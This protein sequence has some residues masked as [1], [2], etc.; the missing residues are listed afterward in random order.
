MRGALRLGRI[1]GIEIGLDYS[2]FII[3][4]LVTWSLAGHYLTHYRWPASTSWMVGLLTSLIFFGSVLAHELGHSL[5]AIRRGVPV[6]GITLFIFGGIAQISKEPERPRD[7]LAIAIAGPI[8]SVLLGL[9]FWSL[10]V[11]APDPRQPAAALAS[12]LGRINVY[13]A[14]FNLLPGFPLDGGR[15]FR[16]IVWGYTGSYPRATRIAAGA[17]QVVAYGFIF[18]G[19][20]MFFAGNWVNGL[21]MAFIGWF[22]N[23]AAAGVLQQMLVREQLGGVKARDVMMTDCPVVSRQLTLQ[24]LVDEYLL[25]T[26]RRCFPVAEE[27]R[28]YGIITLPDVAA[29]PREQRPMVTVGEA[30][31]PFEAT[32]KV[33]PD[34]DLTRVLELMTAEDINQVLVV[35]NGKLLGMISRDRVL[36]FLATRAELGLV[37]GLGAL[38]PVSP[39][40]RPASGTRVRGM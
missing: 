24:D 36:S 6:Q 33:G 11:A 5:V 10:A 39:S 17:G 40:A 7:E 22:L 1:F 13:L 29:V 26:A 30:M 19:L 32:K 34:Q 25:K 23:N 3:F 2:W 16:A 8:V 15:V 28:V 12:W 4:A 31:T 20:S 38:R 14:A 21:W 35:E 9:L 18:L 27:G 37:E